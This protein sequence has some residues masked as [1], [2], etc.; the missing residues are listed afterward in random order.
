MPS[1]PSDAPSPIPT[2]APV[3]NPSSVE[4]FETDVPVG[5]ERSSEGPDVES[6]DKKSDEVVVELAE[7]SAVAVEVVRA[8]ESVVAVE[9]AR[10]TLNPTTAIAPTLDDTDNVVVAI[11]QSVDIPAAVEA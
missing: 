9:V 3:D 2:F 6:R 8:E 4:L 7:R 11:D 10:A 5:D 1:T